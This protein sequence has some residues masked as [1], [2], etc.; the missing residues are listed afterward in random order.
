MYVLKPF[1]SHLQ[2]PWGYLQ[3]LRI[4]AA[5]SSLQLQRTTSRFWLHGRVDQHDAMDT[6]FDF[7]QWRHGAPKNIDIELKSALGG[8]PYNILYIYTYHAHLAVL[9]NELKIHMKNEHGHAWKITLQQRHLNNNSIFLFQQVFGKQS[10]EIRNVS[11]KDCLSGLDTTT[12]ELST[13]LRPV[14]VGINASEKNQVILQPTAFSHAL[15]GQHAVQGRFLLSS[16]P[17]ALPGMQS[18]WGMK[19]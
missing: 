9:K 19:N 5:I 14:R 1:K 3:I 10:G 16:S 13:S 17:L 2:S 6:W 18:F 11:M 12:S 15:Q 8:W 7:Q 4:L